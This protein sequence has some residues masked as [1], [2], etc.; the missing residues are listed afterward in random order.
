MG[1]K[2]TYENIKADIKNGEKNFN[3]KVVQQPDGS[4]LATMGAKPH[5]LIIDAPPGLDG[6]DLGPSPLLVILASVGGCIA[7]VIGFWAKIMDVKIDHIEVFARGHINL[8]GI[9]G[10]GDEKPYY[11]KLRPLIRIKTSE[12]KEKIDE[13][14][15]K[16][17]ERA[18]I[19]NNMNMNSG[20]EWKYEVKS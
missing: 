14:M 19:I 1:F 15:K 9:F 10:I 17:W 8:G 6:K 12:P 4:F 2:E 11:D 20:L 7:A 13:L 18:P 3:V 16:V 5:T